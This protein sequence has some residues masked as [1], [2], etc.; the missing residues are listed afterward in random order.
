MQGTVTKV[1]VTLTGIA[2]GDV[3]ELEALLL[4]P[5]QR[6]VLLMNSPCANTNTVGS[7]VTWTFDDAA[8]APVPT[9]PPCPSGTYKLADSDPGFYSF[10]YPAPAPPYPAALSGFSGAQPNGAWQL[11]VVD[12]TVAGG[13]SI[14]GGWS[15]EL[16]T[17]GPA[18]TPPSVPPPTTKKC[19]KHKRSASSAK[20]KRCKKK[21]R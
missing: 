6:K 14:D 17:T 18:L 1:K 15:L 16:S 11:F 21:R 10:L 3:D 20:K 7:P 5:D 19:K 2:H 13:G 12:D 4:S 9:N 8:A